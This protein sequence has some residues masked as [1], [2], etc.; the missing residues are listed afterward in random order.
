MKINS[1]DNKCSINIDGKGDDCL[2]FEVNASI[3]IGHGVFNGKNTD[4]MF[5]NFDEFIKDYDSFITNRDITP[6]LN[7]TYESF[8]KI[9]A[10]ISNSIFISFSLGDA[11]SGYNNS[12]EFSLNG[13]FEVN[14]E[15][16]IQM[17]TEFKSLAKN[18]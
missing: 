4:L 9:E 14:T 18:A 12:V 10:G 5:L 7:A 1:I 16:L 6:I 8:I 13:K 15:F 2:F 17:H 11:F 3:D